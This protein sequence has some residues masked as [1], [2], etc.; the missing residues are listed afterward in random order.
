MENKNTISVVLPL[1]TRTAYDFESFFEKSIESLKNQKDEFDELVIVHC[2]ESQLESYLTEFDFGGINVKF[3]KWTEE[4]NYSKQVNRGVEVSSSNWVSLLEFDDEYSK[5][6]FRNSKKYM[7][8]YK[9]VD[10][11]LP[12][13]VDVDDKA[14]FAGFTNEATFAANITNE[15]GILSNDILQNFQNFQ[16][17]GMI[18][19]K[20]RFLNVGGL[21]SNIKLTF[22]YE[23]FLRLTHN[24]ARIMTIPRI[25]YKHMNLRLGSLFWNYK[26]SDDRLSADEVKFWI[27]SAK[28]EYFYNLER[29]INY[30]HQEV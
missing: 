3:E 1:K 6:W 26:N 14:V 25:G 30:E 10:A 18:I 12:I 23:F 4:P 13:V 9:D 29:E 5:I 20:E 19:S 8:I 2:D 22:G 27:D 7:D 16:I 28:K 24:S 15:I 17:S 11:F 21:K